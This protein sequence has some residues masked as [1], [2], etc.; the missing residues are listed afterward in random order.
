LLYC[1]FVK[2]F[3]KCEKIFLSLLGMPD[4]NLNIQEIMLNGQISF[5]TI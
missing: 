3:L 2:C 5:D 4:K 1:G